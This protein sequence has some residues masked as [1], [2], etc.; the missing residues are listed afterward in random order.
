MNSLLILF[1]M[2]LLV[3]A[4]GV[5]SFIGDKN[6]GFSF[7]LLPYFVL[8][9]LGQ[10]LYMASKEEIPSHLS[11]YS[12][13]VFDISHNQEST[14]KAFLPLITRN[15][16]VNNVLEAN[17]LFGAPFSAFDLVMTTVLEPKFYPVIALKNNS[18][19]FILNKLNIFDGEKNR[20]IA[21]DS[22]L[23]SKGNNGEIEAIET[24][25]NEI[26]ATVSHPE[27]TILDPDH[28]TAFYRFHLQERI[29]PIPQTNDYL[30]TLSFNQPKIISFDDCLPALQKLDDTNNLT[31]LSP[32][33]I[34]YGNK[35]TNMFYLGCSLQGTNGAA[36][37]SLLDEP[38]TKDF[39]LIKGNG[40]VATN[41]PNTP[42]FIHHINSIE[43]STNLSYLL[44]HGGQEDLSKSINS[45][46]A[47]PIINDPLSEIGT[48]ANINQKPT[49]IFSDRPP[50]HYQKTVLKEQPATET[51]LYT[52]DETKNMH[53]AF[54]G[55]GQLQ[56]SSQTKTYPLQITDI[57]GYKDTVFV[58]TLYLSPDQKGAGGIFYSQ[59]LFN[60][61]GMIKNWTPW[62]RK[63]I[64]GNIL[65]S[66]YIPTLGSSAA[67]FA[68]L[69][70]YP[71]LATVSNVGPFLDM[72]NPLWKN[73]PIAKRGIEQ[74]IDIPWR[75]PAIGLGKNEPFLKSSYM[76]HL[77]YNTVIL[78]Q[79]ARN[80]SL[81]PFYGNRVFICEG[82]N[83]SSIKEKTNDVGYLAFIGGALGEAGSMITATLGYN[84]N[85]KDSWIIAGGTKGLYIL[86][87][88]DGAGFGADGLQDNF[89]GIKETWVW[90]K[91]GKWKDIRKII[92]IDG[93]LFILTRDS[94]HRLPLEYDQL[95]NPSQTKIASIY[96]FPNATNFSTFGDIIVSEDAC[97]LASSIGLFKNKTVSP[98]RTSTYVSW[99]LIPLP[100]SNEATPIH[101]SLSTAG[102]YD[103]SWASGSKDIISSNILIT[104]SSLK[105]HYTKIYRFICYGMSD[106]YDEEMIMILPNFFL[107]SSPTYLY[108]PGLELLSFLS[109]GATHLG[110]GVV[111]STTLFRSF[112]SVFCPFLKQGPMKLKNEFNFFEFSSK[113]NEYTGFPTYCSGN[114]FWILSTENGVQGLC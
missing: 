64:I 47:L 67:I 68:G 74:S 83:T 40:I 63:N 7:E 34:T 50:Y 108:N 30:T 13:V 45:V 110:H 35:D 111:G 91:V 105:K 18:S 76:I 100:E 90:R 42:L 44:V 31:F 51:D 58:S 27:K 73:L 28:N 84:S 71:G 53:E 46:F 95:Q 98:I 19:L 12:L 11:P 106:Q 82:G 86:E 25:Q 65:T 4:K 77:G 62:Q 96:D 107:H 36:G 33:T 72:G 102:G 57:E 92:G 79:T 103:E 29:L 20:I 10:K 101:F 78:Q 32:K 39:S 114:G 15:A 88:N 52:L 112:I 41:N 1:F 56:F 54:V 16:L 43:T 23:D 55:G 6:P 109:D 5:I 94:L 26:L 66:T 14:R 61:D 59:A 70:S 3:E 97:L 81:L 9:P 21:T 75:H 38:I 49:L 8:D 69:S 2:G 99:Q 37:I 104:T 113:I 80:N 89:Q 85:I 17:P 87:N 22:L 60:E 24:I 48:L 93:Y